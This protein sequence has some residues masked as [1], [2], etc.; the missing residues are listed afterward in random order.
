MNNL[1]KQLGKRILGSVGLAISRKV[2]A[3]PSCNTFEAVLQSIVASEKMINVVQV[4]AND[5]SHNDPIYA[6]LMENKEFTKALLIEPQ[7][8]IIQ[9]LKN[10]YTAHPN[11]SIF[12]GAI[13]ADDSL[14]LYRIK[15]ALWS[16]FHAP[17]L[18]DAPDYRAPSGLTSANKAHVI[19]WAREYLDHSLSTEEAIEEIKVPCRRLRELLSEM[20]FPM[21]IHLL[22]VDAEGAD[23]QVIYACDID[24]LRPSIINF[25]S[26]H[27]GNDKKDDLEKYLTC[28][29]Y[30]L[31]D[32]NESD[33]LAIRRPA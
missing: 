1:V 9:Y 33:T 28:N 6:F 2:E 12:N 29:G 27:L 25:E 19:K 7:P 8:D 5:G 11:I 18:K 21:K 4:G 16:S 22:Q 17:Y 32:W 30:K 3:A 26:K 24:E 20:N 10:A 15:P 23:D 31:Y 13:G 14:L